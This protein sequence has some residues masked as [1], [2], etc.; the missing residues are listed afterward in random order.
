MS[1]DGD[2]IDLCKHLKS[3]NKIIEVWSLP[4]VSFN[5]KFCDYADS[6]TFLNKNFFY[7]NNNKQDT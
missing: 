3:K 5:K 7:D 4:G 1:G 2:F 6:I